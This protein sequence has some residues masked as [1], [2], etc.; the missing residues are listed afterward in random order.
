MSKDN[1]FNINSFLMQSFKNISNCFYNT[2]TYGSSN[3]YQEVN[4]V[5]AG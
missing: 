1:E 4:L 3:D 2:N 5:K